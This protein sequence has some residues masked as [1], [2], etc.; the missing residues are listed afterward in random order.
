[1][2]KPFK[3]NVSKDILQEINLKVKNYP[4]HEM[5]DD[6]GWEYGTNLDYM[7]EISNYW[8]NTFDWKKQEEEINKF[9]NYITV[10]D[11]IKIHYILEKGSGPKSMPLRLMHGWP[12]SVVEFLHIIQNLL[13]LKNLEEKKRMLSML[14]FHLYLDLV[15]LVGHH[16]QLDQEKCQKFLIA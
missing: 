5:P 15:F 9:S 10:V 1:M 7:K 11:E 16:A 8:V 12:G 6:G 14:L 3:L 2:T 4:W 13:I